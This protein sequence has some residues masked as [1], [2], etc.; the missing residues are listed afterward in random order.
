MSQEHNTHHERGL[1]LSLAN[2]SSESV[3]AAAREAVKSLS[4]GCLLSTEHFSASEYRPALESLRA[5]SQSGGRKRLAADALRISH[6]P[7]GDPR[8]T[9]HARLELDAAL[10]CARIAHRR[11]HFGRERG[12]LV[13]LDDLR[14]QIQ[15]ARGTF[16]SMIARIRR[17]F[18]GAFRIT[19]YR[20]LSSLCASAFSEARSRRRCQA[21]E[22]VSLKSASLARFGIRQKRGIARRAAVY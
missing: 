13:Q 11:L 22:A 19:D 9:P 16:A 15:S 2:V 5:C 6:T 14:R 7:L 17:L 1:S 8:H 3:A 20:G 4:R 12:N 10:E 18:E 21:S